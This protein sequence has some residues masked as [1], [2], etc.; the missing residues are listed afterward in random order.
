MQVLEA[1]VH[2]VGRK[3]TPS[4]LPVEAVEVAGVAEAEVGQEAEVAGDPVEAVGDG[5][6][7]GRGLTGVIRVRKKR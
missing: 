4:A 6:Q 2:C 5:H 3:T 7:G 1:R